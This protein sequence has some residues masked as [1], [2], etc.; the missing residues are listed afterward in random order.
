MR[1]EYVVDNPNSLDT[2]DV[3]DSLLASRRNYPARITPLGYG[4]AFAT[5]E[6]NSSFLVKDMVSQKNIL[7]DCGSLVYKEL[8]DRELT[9]KIDWV[10]ITHT[11]EDHIGS[12]STLIYENWYIHKKRLKILCHPDVR[13]QLTAYL[14]TVCNHDY[15]H[16]ELEYYW[17]DNFSKDFPSLKLEDFRTTN[18]HFPNL[19]TSGLKITILDQF[20]VVFSGDLGVSVA[21]YLDFDKTLLKEGKAVIFQDAGSYKFTKETHEVIPH[22]FYQDCDNPNTFIY[23]HFENEVDIINKGL[24]NAKSISSLFK[25]RKSLLFYY[26]K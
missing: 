9:D 19:P 5:V 13:H 26:Y 3:A 22:A 14:V 17:Q 7:I 15:E 12:L 16:F 24:E 6:G 25:E 11:H 23:H 21:D 1:I 8:R 20:E 18:L 4:G 10:Y 2:Q